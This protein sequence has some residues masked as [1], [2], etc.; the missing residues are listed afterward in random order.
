V[1]AVAERLRA[2]GLKVWFDKWEIKVG[3]M[4]DALL[5]AAYQGRTKTLE[6]ARELLERAG[7]IEDG[8]FRAAMQAILEVL[9]VGTAFS[10]VDLPD[11]VVGAGNDFESLEKPGRLAFADQVESPQQFMLWQIDQSGK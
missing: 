1:R 4:I 5:H 3:G 11:D 7:I 2:D 10:G 8:N 9:P 6:A